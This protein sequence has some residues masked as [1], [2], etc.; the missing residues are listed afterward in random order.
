MYKEWQSLIDLAAAASEQ[1]T[2]MFDK[3]S[4]E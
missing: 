1:P 2:S 4:A 3:R